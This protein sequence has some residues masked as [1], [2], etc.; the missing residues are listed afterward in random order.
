MRSTVIHEMRGFTPRSSR[1][2]ILRSLRPSSSAVGW[3]SSE[4]TTLTV[5]AD[6]QQFYLQDEQLE[7]D[8]AE[9][10][11]E[12][13]SA[14]MIATGP[15]V[16][17]V[18]TARNYHVPVTVQVLDSEPEEDLGPWDHVAEASLEFP[19]G[20]LMVYGPTEWPNV[21]RTEVEPGYYRVRVYYAGLETVSP[22][23]IDG[24]DFYQV[25]LWLAD[26]YSREP[27]VLKR[28]DWSLKHSGRF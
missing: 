17:G 9:I 20:C 4:T 19:S 11:D 1:G 22:N 26:T 8:L 6:Y 10:W 24:K 13:T 23:G 7:A 25:V 21:T 15:G 12:R 27:R 14:D 28:S 3:G 18:C 16:V 5:F 2:P